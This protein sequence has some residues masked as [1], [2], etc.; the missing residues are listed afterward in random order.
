MLIPSASVFIQP[1]FPLWKRAEEQRSEKETACQEAIM[2]FCQAFRHPLSSLRALIGSDTQDSIDQEQS[3]WNFTGSRGPKNICFHE[4]P[5]W[6]SWDHSQGKG[7]ARRAG[8]K[9]VRFL[10]RHPA[11]QLQSALSACG[12][13][14]SM[15]QR[16]FRLICLPASPASQKPYAQTSGRLTQFQT[17]FRPF[18]FVKIQQRASN[19]FFSD[20]P[21]RFLEQFVPAKEQTVPAL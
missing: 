12:L 10:R 16:R 15:Q 21:P 17:V 20:T 5:N 14:P 13:L 6:Q 2:N 7:S 1:G 19:Q 3:V 18:V 11:V 4:Q 8:R 9:A